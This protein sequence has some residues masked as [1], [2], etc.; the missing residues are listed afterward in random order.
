MTTKLRK[1][2]VCLLA[3]AMLITLIPC[4]ALHARAA[5]DYPLWV[6][7]EQ[8]T[9]EKLTVNGTT[10]TAVYTPSTNTL[11]LNDYTYTGTGHNNTALRYEGSTA[12][13]LVLEGTSSLTQSNTAGASF[14]ITTYADMV[15]SGGETVAQGAAAAFN[16]TPTIDNAFTN[17][18]YWFGEDKTAADSGGEQDIILLM[19]GYGGSA[20]Y[21]RIAAGTAPTTCT[22]QFK[23]NNGLN[24]TDSKTLAD[25]STLTL[26]GDVFTYGKCEIVGWNTEADG[27]G[28]P[29][30]IGQ[31]IPVDQDLT[32]YAQWA[33]PLYKLDSFS[34]GDYV[35]SGKAAAPY[36]FT[37]K[38]GAV[39]H[40]SVIFPVRAGSDKTVFNVEGDCEVKGSLSFETG[41]GQSGTNLRG[42]LTVKG[43]GTLEFYEFNGSG[44]GDTITVEADVTVESGYT[45]FGA[46]GG[47]DSRLVIK[48][49]TLTLHDLTMLQYL[50]MEGSAKLNI[51]GGT[52]SFHG[53]PEINLSDSSV[54]YIGGNGFECVLYKDRED[55][56]DD[57]DALLANGW[58]PAGFSFK[59]EN[60][61]YYLYN[62]ANT[63]AT[64]P[65]TI[66]KPGFTV[67]F[68]DW[69]G[70]VLDTQYVSPGAAAAAP[71]DPTRAGWT[72]TGWDKAFNNV[73][74][75]LIVTAQYV[76]QTGGGGGGVRKY[77][78]TF[79]SN[80]GSNVASKYVNKN[81]KVSQPAAP[82]KNGFQFEGWYTDKALTDSYDFSKPVTRS[83]TLYAKW[84]E[85]SAGTSGHDC[86]SLNFSDLD[87]TQW[88]HLDTDYVIGNDIFRGTA[89]TIFTPHGNITRAMMITVLY[90]AEG[91]PKVTGKATFEDIDETAYYAKAVVWG[92]QNGIIKGY[93]DTRYAPDQDILREQI[94]AIM[95]RFAKYKGYDVSVGERTD[96]RSYSD[97]GSISGY[98]IPSLQ[99]AVGS[100]MVKGRTLSTLNPLDHATRVEVAAM[101]HRFLETNK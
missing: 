77:S 16:I 11:T 64:D 74:G 47:L 35:W 59:K 48:D 100:G 9:S 51:I 75:D 19:A 8:L 83:F 1:L 22:V 31:S 52:A 97:Y 27:S 84:S 3:L 88:Y 80:G 4:F 40:A 12:L 99:W 14:G 50:T 70:D 81:A 24:E 91:E 54:I 21:I 60:Y 86:P 55:G 10:G 63:L 101:L 25:G 89:K 37:M 29:Y 92:Q 96:I 58:I 18:K 95:H 7:G 71:A 30:D 98:A 33:L 20:K 46:S 45:F 53:A 17:A 32:L 73:T 61:S 68:M 69:D 43:S 85:T 15:I 49:A 5:T 82:T 23:S 39:L 34:D 79:N 76:Q 41:T 13:N 57:F 2:T 67:T 87:V 6:G 65:L 62:A 72:F 42:D 78:V 36:S 93:S 28:Y 94:A 44:S 56:N 90:R 66:R 38:N 26:P